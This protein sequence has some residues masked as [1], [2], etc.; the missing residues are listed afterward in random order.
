ME[1]IK[2][3]RA[4]TCVIALMLL[5]NAA[6]AQIF[7]SEPP[8]GKIAIEERIYV[9]DGTCPAGQIKE[10]I[11]GNP[12]LGTSRTRK[13]VVRDASQDAMQELK[14]SV[15][16]SLEQGSPNVCGSTGGNRID[17]V[18]KGKRLTARLPGGGEWKLG[19]GRLNNDGSGR[20]V[21]A[22]ASSGHEVDFDF[23]AGKGPRN[24]RVTR[25]QCV[26]SWYL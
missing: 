6:Q 8:P 19:L 24:I 18:I 9:D 15:I 4:L 11:G 13:C 1:F 26:W 23:A 14:W 17:I 16:E 2:T 7:K 22:A 3:M 21:A 10:V 20:I 5:S 25:D 12:R